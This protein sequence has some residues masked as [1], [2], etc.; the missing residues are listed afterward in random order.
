MRKSIDI[1]FFILAVLFFMAWI[2][3]VILNSLGYI[4]TFSSFMPF[5]VGWF[6]FGL[7]GLSSYLFFMFFSEGYL[8]KFLL[9]AVALIGFMMM[10][11]T[12]L[13]DARST[14][15]EEKSGYIFLVEEDYFLRGGTKT[16]YQ[17][18][19]PWVSRKIA[20]C[21]TGSDV[22]CTYDVIDDMLILHVCGTTSDDSCYIQSYPLSEKP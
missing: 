6:I 11:Y 18:M 21:Y 14:V 5:R 3:H 19:N 2:G 4:Y 13:W 7:F 20:I 12:I 10:V 15:I 8:I 17:K 16:I 9:T 1:V 22:S